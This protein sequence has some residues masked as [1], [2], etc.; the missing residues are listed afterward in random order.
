MQSSGGKMQTLLFDI[1]GTLL[2]TG[3]AGMHAIA[4]T[5]REMFGIGELPSL[6]LHGRTDHGI[7]QELFQ[8][9]QLDFQKHYDPFCQRYCQLLPDSLLEIPGKVLP[10]VRELLGVLSHQ[11][12]IKL[13][14]LTGNSERAANIKL[15]KFDL[16]TYFQFGGFGDWHGSRD[17]VAR[18]AIDAARMAIGS[19][20]ERSKVWVI[21]DTIQ[22]IR[23]A[24]AIG[25]KVIAVLTGGCSRQELL[26][27]KP[28]FLFT[29]IES[30]FDEFL[31]L[32]EVNSSSVNRRQSDR[33][34]RM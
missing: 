20:F 9:L 29:S 5:M 13:G 3:G 2:S 25:S 31:E 26:E 4:Q 30:H 19:G 22:D 6:N 28:D 34:L 10:G 11:P 24:R 14:L 32:L 18:K 21:G 17:D 8:H 7:L 12:Q 33:N 15:Q 16:D 23:C 27:A 1:D